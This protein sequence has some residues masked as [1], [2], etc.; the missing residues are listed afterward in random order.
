MKKDTKNQGKG[1]SLRQI[2][3]YESGEL[4]PKIP[5]NVNKLRIG[6]ISK[7]MERG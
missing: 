4:K 2:Y 6:D 1:W 5:S 3:M 7:S